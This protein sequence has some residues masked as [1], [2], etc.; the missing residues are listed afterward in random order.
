MSV[1]G[2]K[3]YIKLFKNVQNPFEYIFNRGKRKIRHLQFITRPNSIQFEVP[4]TLYPVFKEIFMEDV[5]NISS[6]EKELPA[7][8]IVIDIGANAGFFDIL[9]LSKNINA[10]IYAYEPLP[11]NVSQLQKLISA[12]PSLQKKFYPHQMAVTGTP[13][14]NIELYMEAG[15]QS[16]VVASVFANFDSRNSQKI[17]VKCITLTNIILLN[18][19][20]KI[21]VM[22]IDCEGSEYDILYNTDYSLICRAKMLLIEVHDLDNDKYNITALNNYLKKIGYIT[23]HHPINNFCH[24]LEAT[25]KN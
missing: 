6:V 14:E 22:K 1:S 24:A 3:R 21:D 19:L 16:S 25:L 11:D 5:Y 20:L 8:P 10:T 9:L 12:N 17:V 15:T 2:Y 18:N 7:N 4:G 23:S 13:K